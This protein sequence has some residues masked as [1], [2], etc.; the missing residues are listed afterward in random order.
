MTNSRAKGAAGE[1]ELANKLKEYGYTARRTQQFCDKAGDSDV[2]CEELD[3][4]HI[5]VKR[6]ERLN[7]DN[8]MDQSLRDCQERTPIV[9]HRRNK[10][11]WM[12]TMYLEDWLALQKR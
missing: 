1:R 8:A 7:I 11:P 3:E 9:V 4:Y 10:K 5:E 6:V 12:V 2:V